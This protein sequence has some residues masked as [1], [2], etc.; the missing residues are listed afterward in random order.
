MWQIDSWQRQTLLNT[1]IQIKKNSKKML[2]HLPPFLYS[3]ICYGSAYKMPAPPNYVFT[4]FSSVGFFLCLIKFPTQ[5]H[6]RSHWCS[7]PS[8]CLKCNYSARNVGIHLY[9]AWV[10]LQCLFLG[11][12]S[13]MWNHN[14]VN[15][16]P[17]WCDI[18]QFFFWFNHWWFHQCLPTL[19][20]LGSLSGFL[21]LFQLQSFVSIVVFTCWHL[22]LVQFLPKRTRIAKSSLLSCDQ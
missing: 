21:L 22:W 15:W 2:P 17:V 12:N 7:Y 18:S 13:I 19:K 8:R 5:F 9:L 14:T 4:I 1:I 10:G 3:S 11:I 20:R 16:A 6:G